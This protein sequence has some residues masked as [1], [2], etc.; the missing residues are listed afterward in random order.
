MD[1]V[2]PLETVVRNWAIIT[3]DKFQENLMRNNIGEPDGA[4]MRSFTT[5]LQ[6][7]GN[8]SMT[9]I[10][11]FLKYGRFVD[12]GVGR[13]QPL[14]A[15]NV[16]RSRNG[17]RFEKSG[18]RHPKKWYGKT[19]TKSAYILNFILMRNYGLMALQTLEQQLR[20]TNEQ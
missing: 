20:S 10:I 16:T 17:S 3:M 5:E 14:G 7:N 13:G 6:K 15:K 11:K 9:V 8:D 1:E 18:F 19:K 4:L 12:M 2:K